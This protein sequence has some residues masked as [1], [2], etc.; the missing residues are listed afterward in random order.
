MY[1]EVIKCMRTDVV[2]KHISRRIRFN[3]SVY[4]LK[5]I[6]KIDSNTLKLTYELYAVNA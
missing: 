1:V 4:I 3:D 6:E 5:R 2:L